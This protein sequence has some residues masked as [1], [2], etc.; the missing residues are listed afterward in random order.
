[1]NVNHCLLNGLKKR[2]VID[3]CMGDVKNLIKIG[4]IVF[5]YL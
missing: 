3:G 4:I 5:Q 1:M 2:H